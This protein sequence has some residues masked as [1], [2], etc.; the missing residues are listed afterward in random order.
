MVLG[1]QCRMYGRYVPAAYKP[2]PWKSAIV[3]VVIPGVEELPSGKGEELNRGPV[4]GAHR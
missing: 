4:L 1:Y 3:L 2:E